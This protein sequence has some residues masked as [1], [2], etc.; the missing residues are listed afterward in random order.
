MLDGLFEL[1]SWLLNFFYHVIPNY[2]VAIALLT[3]VVMLV[4]TPLTM[5]GTRSMIEMQRLQP[6]IRRLQAEYKDDRQ[7]MN[8]EM[9]RFY[10]ENQ[11]NPLGGC[12]PLLVQAPVF[13]VLF[14]VVRGLIDQAN[15]VGVQKALGGYG[16]DPTITEG[17][18][19][20]YLDQSAEL[21]QALL[22]QNEMLSFG[23]DLALS[24]TE[25]LEVG[26]VTAL[27]YLVLVL[28][29]AGLSWIQQKQ[30][31]G[32]TPAS[33]MTQQQ[34]VMMR[35]VPIMLPFFTLFFPAALG[36]YW[37]VSTVWRVG[38]QA[39]ITRAL[40]RGEDAIGVQAQKAM[41]QARAVQKRD[42]ARAATGTASDAGAK[43]SGKSSENGATRS[44]RPGRA[45]Q[46][47]SAGTATKTKPKHP[48]S[49]KKKKRKR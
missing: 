47:A 7:K 26:F 27:P 42:G 21:Y 17:F 30:I 35:V 1:I 29:I 23:V 2:A 20:R 43:P 34:K 44:K 12:L 46:P 37:L 36:V 32:R 3:C 15:F 9:M 48:R 11:I 40:Y 16:I 6:E 5:K 19:P 39:Y 45:A 10:R 8:E 24:P 49:R 14:W 33:Q 22:G 4:T 38:Q 31:M 18:K 13:I 41:A 28:V 25:A